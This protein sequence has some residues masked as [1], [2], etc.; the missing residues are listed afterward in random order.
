MQSLSKNGKGKLE[1][2]THFRFA[3]SKRKKQKHNS[4]PLSFCA[5]K[6]GKGKTD[7]DN[8]DEIVRMEVKPFTYC[9]FAV[10]KI[11]NWY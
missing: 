3:Q 1:S 9:R 10:M 6:N 7:D 8:D 2:F 4:Y 5:F 11:E